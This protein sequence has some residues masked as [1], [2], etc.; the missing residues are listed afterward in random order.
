MI[1]VPSAVLTTSALLCAG[2]GIDNVKLACGM[3]NEHGVIH[4]SSEFCGGAA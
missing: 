1:S 3:P 4:P 2:V